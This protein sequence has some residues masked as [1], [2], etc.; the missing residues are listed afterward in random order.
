[1]LI[2]EQ[3]LSKEQIDF[4]DKYVPKD[5]FDRKKLKEYL[6]VHDTVG[7]E[8]F[9]YCD[10]GAMAVDRRS[11]RS[12]Y[13]RGLDSIC[14]TPIPVDKFIKRIPFYFGVKQD[15]HE[16]RIFLG[17]EMKEYTTTFP[18]LEY[19]FTGLWD[20]LHENW[21]E[22]YAQDINLLEK[23]YTELEYIFYEMSLPLEESLTYMVDQYDNFNAPFLSW[24]DYIHLCE[25][26]GWTDYFPTS[27]IYS[28]DKALEAAGRELVIYGPDVSTIFDNECRIKN[29]Y[30]FRGAFPSD[31]NGVPVLKWCGLDVTNA[32]DI[33][34]EQEK[35]K[36]NGYLWIDLLPN[37][38]IRA[39]TPDAKGGLKWRLVYA[40][41]QCM[42]FDKRVIKER[43]NELG[44]T[45][46]NVADA[47]EISVR[48]YQKWESGE[49]IPDGYS[50]LKLMN[51]LNL[52]DPQM[53]IK[54]N[55]ES[56]ANDA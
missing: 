19:V 48:T 45:Q 12:H 30:I 43:R 24:A 35:S 8:V 2:K 26:L 28:Y 32:G 37:T 42:E 31:E 36:G 40:G 3:K 5:C 39:F 4:I 50:L 20:A 56:E 55:T 7:N 25:D 46:K 54:Y 10:L 6:N 17:V 49:T 18:L 34:C 16:A 22:Q 13:Y 21:I 33:L 51:W 14:F 29:T 15:V 52:P 9:A 11:D 1:M 27:F 41:P 23:V 38:V 53:L 47:L 44:L